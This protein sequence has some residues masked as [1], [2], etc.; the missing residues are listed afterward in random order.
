MT[1]TDTAPRNAT[2]GDN[3]PPVSLPN[4][5]Q[6]LADLQRRF[7]EMDKRL[8]EW[9]SAF[10]TFPADIPLDQEDVAQ[11]LQDL[12]G[13]VKKESKTW[14]DS[15][16]KNEKK[17][18]NALVKI[19]G[20]FFTG[21]AEKADKMLAQWMPVHETFLRRKADAE[22]AR[23]EA[24]AA[25][26]REKERIA[27]EAAER[28][29]AEQRAA[30]ERAAEQRRIEAEERE[31]AEKAKRDREEAE[32]RAAEAA[33]K[34]KAE[35]EAKAARD[36]EEKERN[37]VGLR[38]IRGHLR[39]AE[40]LHTLVAADEASESEIARLDE[41]VRPAGII[42]NIAGPVAAS[43]L[44]DDG[45]TAQ[46]AALRADMTKMRETLASN[47]GKREAA[48]REKARLEEEKRQQEL[49]AE[50]KRQADEEAA[51]L[52]AAR[53]VRE[54]EE[55]AAEKA[56]AE[57]LA[58]EQAAR[59]ARDRAA[60]EQRDAKAAGKE[61][62][63]QG[64]EADRSGNRATRTENKLENSS[65]ADLSRTRGERGTVGGLARRW[66][67]Y[68]VDE[69]ALRAACGP[70]GPYLTSDAL[71]GACTNW[72]RAHQASFV[73]ERVEPAEL[74][75]VVFAYETEARIA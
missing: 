35:R 72:M 22:R 36:R 70:L 20:N 5:D 57:R 50:R 18:L 10:K 27:R 43:L 64:A 17:P 29:A 45:Q 6:M 41:L 56:K 65:E 8:A 52:E 16:Q 71:E 11:S 15:Y 33:A 3:F 1:Q 60:S 51:R 49:A 40:N 44:L 47:I 28:A 53:K 19:V 37:N 69:D 7:P 26:Q 54:A 4:D 66:V 24:A 39:E 55:A 62:R 32:R 58:A 2:I 21:R 34:E 13:Q 30:E 59:E 73:G 31:K 12:L 14:T 61:A 74:P 63:D 68:V 25:E 9:D 46:V 38:E 48:K 42:S 67:R 23:A 75:G